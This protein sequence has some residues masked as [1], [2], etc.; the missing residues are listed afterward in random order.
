MGDRILLTIDAC[1]DLVLG[2]LLMAFPATVVEALGVPTAT[3]AF[4]P[5]LLGAV[6]LGIGIALWL[7][8]SGVHSGLGLDGAVAINMCGG[9]VLAIWLLAGDLGLPL[10]GQVL[11]WGLV[12]VLVGLSGLELTVRRARRASHSDPATAPNGGDPDTPG[13][14]GTSDRPIERHP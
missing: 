13:G 4:Y 1:V 12:V 8:R 9:I 7:E 11:L 6:L 14:M 2:V 5:S 10:R 3:P